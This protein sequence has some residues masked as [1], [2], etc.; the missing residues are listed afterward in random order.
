MDAREFKVTD[1]LS[2]NERFIVPLYQRQYQWHDHKNY[3]GRTSAFWLDVVAKAA[4][5]LAGSAKFDHYMGALLL[6]PDVS[7]RSFGAT[8]I[9]HVVDG[10]QRLTTFMILLA[11]LREIARSHDYAVLVEQIEKYLFNER[12][13]ADTDPLAKYKLTPTPVDRPVFLDILDKPYAEVRAS[14]GEF[15]WGAAVPQNTQARALRAYEYFRSQIAEFV[16]SGASDDTE[17]DID[18]AEQEEDANTET[19]AET[20]RKRMDAL[21]EALVFHLKLIVITLDEEDDAQVIFET[22]NSKSQPLL[23]MD[24]VRNNIF[25]RADAQYRS[26]ED[27]RA[28]AERL[29]HEVWEPFDHGWW[30]ENAPN[31]RPARPRIDHF[32]AAVLTAETGER[33]TVRELYAEYRGWATPGRRARF[34]NVEDELA[35]L[36]RHVPTYET[37]EKRSGGDDAIV[38]LGERLRL[39]QNTT[40]YPIAF[41]IAESGVDEETRWAVCRLLDSYLVRRLL[42]DLTP[43]NLNQVFPRLSDALRSHGISVETVSRFFATQSRDTTRFPNDIE[44]RKGIVERRAYGRIPSRVLTDLLWSLELE[45][46]SSLTENT[47]R[48]SAIWVEHVMPQNWHQNWPLNGRY[49]SGGDF[50]TPGYIDRDI[51][52]QTLGNLTITT[53]K[54]NITMSNL[55]FDEKAQLLIDHSNLT[56][57]RRIAENTHWDEAAILSRSEELSD[58]AV[59]IWPPVS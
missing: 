19:D 24:L 57:N 12:G 36:Q 43:K 17:V 39:W 11:A 47:A 22:L 34:E 35:V 2:R 21:L 9:V 50:E 37:L 48:P 29:Y 58:L 27:S 10:Q 56:L 51:S 15:Y 5:V 52:I 55:G 23:A 41:Q 8:P 45:S 26:D 7:Q 49:V 31:A 20:V 14:N 28:K 25:H 44:V 46:R 30:R 38:W 1:V 54:L 4:E 59:K 18:E 33:I 16:A 42:C 3:E 53:D 6:A 13:R 32:L 40:A